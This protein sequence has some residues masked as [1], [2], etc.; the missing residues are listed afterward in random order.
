VR[1]LL[2]ENIPIQL[3]R[4]LPRHA[5]RSVNDQDVDWKNLKNGVLLDAMEGAFD[6]LVTADGNMYAQQRLVGRRFSILVPPTNRRKVVLALAERIADVV[7]GISLGEY[8]TLGLTGNVRK[9]SFD[10]LA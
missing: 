5:V 1:I 9:R 4:A 2:D 6:L 7:D 3:K 8:V 10:Q